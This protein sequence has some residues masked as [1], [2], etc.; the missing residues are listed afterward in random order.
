MSE[1]LEDSKTAAQSI[2]GFMAEHDAEVEEF[3]KNSRW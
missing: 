3:N 1:K 2:F